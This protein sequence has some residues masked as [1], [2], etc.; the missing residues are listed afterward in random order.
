MVCKADATVFDDELRNL[1]STTAATGES[2]WER[3]LLAQ[4][5]GRLR[6]K[7][8]DEPEQLFDAHPPD[9]DF[10]APIPAVSWVVSSHVEHCFATDL[11]ISLTWIPRIQ[12]TS[13]P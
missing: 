11:R 5:E 12:T 4:R 13:S 9:E 10:F 2:L 7:N 6:P 8:I 3:D 1:L